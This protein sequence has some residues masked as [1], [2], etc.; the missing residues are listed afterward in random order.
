[1][2]GILPGAFLR[3][4]ASAFLA[5]FR[6][7][8]GGFGGFVAFDYIRLEQLVAEHLADGFLSES[9]AGKEAPELAADE[10]EDGFRLDDLG[11][12]VAVELLAVAVEAG[13]RFLLQALAAEL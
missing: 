8:L 3:L 7:Q 13:D 1:M 6:H 11:E 2:F 9:E 5:G 10:L 4:F 12:G